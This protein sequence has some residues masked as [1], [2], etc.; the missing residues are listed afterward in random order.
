MPRRHLNEVFRRCSREGLS[1]RL[2]HGQFQDVFGRLRMVPVD[3]SYELVVNGR[4]QTAIYFLGLE[5]SMDLCN[6]TH[7]GIGAGPLDR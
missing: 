6:S 3:L 4:D 1:E 2:D 7:H 5:T